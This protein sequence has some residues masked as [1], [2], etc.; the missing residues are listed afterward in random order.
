M[1]AEGRCLAR[2]DRAAPRLPRSDWGYYMRAGADRV[3]IR[4]TTPRLPPRGLAR[5][6]Q[7]TGL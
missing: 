1:S 3:S 5:G 6:G 7:S 4:R 2:F